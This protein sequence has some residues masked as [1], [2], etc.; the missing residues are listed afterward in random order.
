M[1]L[2]S[3]IYCGLG[4]VDSQ[5]RFRHPCKLRGEFSITAAEFQNPAV[6]MPANQLQGNEFFD[7]IILS[8]SLF[9]RIIE[10]SIH[11]LE[12][13]YKLP[14]LDNVI[15]ITLVLGHIRL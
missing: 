13:T 9:P 12:L 15:L 10:I 14:V 7:G 3:C 1:P 8:G 6:A 5:Y 11:L 4:D 2:L